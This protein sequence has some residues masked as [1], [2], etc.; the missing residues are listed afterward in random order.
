MIYIYIFL[1]YVFVIL[2]L[3][4]DV[5]VGVPL[6]TKDAE[7]CQACK[8]SW[9][10]D[11]V[12]TR[13]FAEDFLHSFLRWFAGGAFQHTLGGNHSFFVALQVRCVFFSCFCNGSQA[14]LNFSVMSWA[15]ASRSGSSV[16][17]FG[18]WMNLSL[19]AVSSSPLCS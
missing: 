11:I 4:G 17:V 5:C 16:L 9:K 8:V 7:Y 1:V 15:L 18:S 2:N 14:I 19:D 3:V 6:S 12:K 10:V 13:L